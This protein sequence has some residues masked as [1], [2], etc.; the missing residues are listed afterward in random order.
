MGPAIDDDV[1]ERQCKDVL[2][3]RQLDQQRAQQRTC[4]QVE[5][6]VAF[7]DRNL[8]RLSFALLGPKLAEV[9][10]RHSELESWS[11]LLNRIAVLH[12]E[13]RAQRFMAPDDLI[14]GSF[15]DRMIHWSLQ[16]QIKTVVV[17]RARL[18]LMQEPNP[19]LR[20]G[21]RFLSCRWLG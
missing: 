15:K 20:K 3:L 13:C 2:F 1:I 19:L 10:D 5:E 11:D 17:M 21:K 8:P 7:V 12:V 9:N 6:F 4:L 18:E 16:S 14:D